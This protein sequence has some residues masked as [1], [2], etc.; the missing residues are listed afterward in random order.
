MTGTPL[1]RRRPAVLLVVVVALAAALLTAQSA[2]AHDV[3]IS[4]SPAD[5]AS[6]GATPAT[7]TLTF[8]Q[9]ALKVGTALKI[10]GPT[11]EVT[12]GTATLINNEVH[13]AIAPGAP[14]GRYRV[15]WRV[16]SADGHPVSGTFTFTSTT[17]GAGHASTTPPTRTVGPVQTASTTPSPWLWLIPSVLVLAAAAVVTARIRRHPGSTP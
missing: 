12:D 14:A 10:T 13:Q 6:I 8:D 1:R 11:G 3:L 16:T 17:A 9:P 7:V 4:T 5:G 15:D 2:S